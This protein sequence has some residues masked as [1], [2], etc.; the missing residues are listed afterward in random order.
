M[1]INFSSKALDFINLPRILRSKECQEYLPTNV[2]GANTPMVVYS[3]SK[4]IRSQL[5]SY[6]KFVSE[7]DL[8]TFIDNIESI[9]CHCGSF[10]TSFV[11][12]HHKHILTGNLD[13]LGNTKLI[14]LFS[15]GPKFRE[16]A[17]VDWDKARQEIASAINDYIK[18][19]SS[20]KSIQISQFQEW[21]TNLLKLVDNK[22]A[23]LKNKINPKETISILS[24]NICKKSL[25][26]IHNKF[27]LVPIDKAA[28]N[29]A[30]ICKRFYA[31]VIVK[32]LGLQNINSANSST[33]ESLNIDIADIMKSHKD[34]LTEE[35]NINIDHSME[36]LPT[37]Y[38]IPK[39]HKDPIGF[40][41]IVASP[42]CTVKHLSKDITSVFKLFHKQIQ[43]YHRKRRFWS[44]I[45][46]F[47]VI[48][49]NNPV[50]NSLFKINKRKSAKHISTFDFSTL[51]T[52]IPHDKLIYVLNQVIDFAFTGG[53][54]N[55]ICVASGI[56]NW[57]K[58]NSRMKGNFYTL[59]K[60]KDAVMF[61]L[62][63]CYFVVGL[64][65]FRQRIGIPMGSDPAPFF[66]NLF[67][68]HYESE[69][70]HNMKKSDQ[71]RA[72]KFGI[73]FRL[74]DDLVAI[75]DGLEFSKSYSEIYP[76]E[77]ALKKENI[78]NNKASFLDL[79]VNLIDKEFHTKL[80][81]KRNAFKFSVVRFP[82]K[83]SNIPSKMFFSTIS[84]EVLRICRATSTYNDFLLSSNTLLTKIKR[85][86]ADSDGIKKSP[87]E[88]AISA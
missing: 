31:S 85:Q 56:A 16:P 74:I 21:K 48:Q 14:Q 62:S 52:K 4:P 88:N 15:K 9:P 37:M 87:L 63:N 64:Q 25:R 22:I 8:N 23:V 24:D 44:G 40:R 3:L 20:D 77:L 68:F 19:I 76:S 46:T 71:C 33:Y 86:G 41:F 1:K 69:W 10:D 50:I 12:Q 11:D 45:N 70:L 67:L 73:I 57:V 82:Y 18:R 65:I 84:A 34:T 17:I 7:L 83:C 35:F 53:T 80:Y 75:N 13:I 42:K 72:R 2:D 36:L 30:F 5:F 59:T 55:R 39:I 28:N 27:V 66:A 38:W 60:I 81:D 32:E 43:N 49:N 51:Y 79:E 61:L 54:R 47:W 58:G 26:E 29:I 6:H 78:D